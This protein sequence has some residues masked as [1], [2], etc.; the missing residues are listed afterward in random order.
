MR[1]TGL[2]LAAPFLVACTGTTGYQLVTFYAA[3]EGVADAQPGQPYNFM[4]DRFQVSLTKAVLHI[5]AM[6]LDESLPTSGAAE[7]ACTLP[8]T[9]VGEVRAGRDIDML[10]PS[11]QEFPVLAGAIAPGLGSTIPAA[12]GQVWLSGPDVNSTAEQTAP[13]TILPAV[14]V[15]EGTATD[16]TNAM[17]FPFAGSI[18]I[19]PRSAAPPNT[20]LPGTNPICEQR[21]VSQIRVDITL[22]QAG[23]LILHLDPKPLF[24]KADFSEFSEPFSKDPLLYA[25][26]D[27]GQSNSDQPSRKLYENLRASGPVYRFEWQPAAQ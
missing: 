16:T 24:A 9:Y 11:P 17:A 7:S 3:G 26:Q 13:G 2:F 19:K 1:F 14:L 5:G 10:D 15:V 23:R 27:Q 8:G 21:I 6:Y 20:A 18:S 4:S 22:S 12:V 25:F